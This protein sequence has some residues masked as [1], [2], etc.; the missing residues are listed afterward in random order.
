MNKYIFRKI[1][2]VS[3][4][5]VVGLNL[6]FTTAFA[7]DTKGTGTIGD[8]F[9]CSNHMNH[10]GSCGYAEPD[11][12]M[13]PCQHEHDGDCGYAPAVEEAPC[14]MDCV[15]EDGDGAIAVSYTHLDVYKR[16]VP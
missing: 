3:L 12:I 4:A 9:I 14:D 2:I 16:Q 13:S 10:D 8:G 11:E 7:T 1:A 5:A 15:D 6:V